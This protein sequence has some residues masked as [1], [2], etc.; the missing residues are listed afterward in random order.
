MSFVALCTSRIHG[1]GRTRCRRVALADSPPNKGCF[2]ADGYFIVIFSAATFAPGPKE[3]AAAR[4]C[5]SGAS[6]YSSRISAFPLVPPFLESILPG[7][8]SY[9]EL[10]GP[11]RGGTSNNASFTITRKTFAEFLR[12]S[13][14]QGA[15]NSPAVDHIFRDPAAQFWKTSACRQLVRWRD[16]IASCKGIRTAILNAR[17]RCAARTGV[18]DIARIRARRTTLT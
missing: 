17:A 11:G 5:V 14:S 15:A 4:K 13:H 2:R 8:H 16:S 3:P 7:F 10:W 1:E 18:Y 6:L 12:C 9:F